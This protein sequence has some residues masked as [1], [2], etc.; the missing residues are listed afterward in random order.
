MSA[1]G[2]GLTC[3]FGYTELHAV[4]A[5]LHLAVCAR[6]FSVAFRAPWHLCCLVVGGTAFNVVFRALLS[7]VCSSTKIS[8]AVH[9]LFVSSPFSPIFLSHTMWAGNALIACA[10]AVHILLRSSEAVGSAAK[11]AVLGVVALLN[12]VAVGWWWTHDLTRHT[13]RAVGTTTLI[14]QISSLF[15]AYSATKSRSVACVAVIICPI[16]LMTN[17]ALAYVFPVDL[18][19]KPLDPELDDSQLA[20]HFSVIL[21]SIVFGAANLA[22]PAAI[23]HAASKL[24]P[25]TPSWHCNLRQISP[26]LGLME[27]P[28]F[29]KGSEWLWL[30]VLVVFAA[31]MTPGAF[32]DRSSVST[33]FNSKHMRELLSLDTGQGGIVALLRLLFPCAGL[34]GCAVLWR[35][36]A[37]GTTQARKRQLSSMGPGEEGPGAQ[38]LQ[39]GQQETTDQELSDVR[40]VQVPHKKQRSK[41]YGQGCTRTDERAGWT[42]EKKADGSTQRPKSKQVVGQVDAA[43]VA[44]GLMNHSVP[45]WATSHGQV[46][47][48]PSAAP[49]Q[50]TANISQE[51]CGYVRSIVRGLIKWNAL[52]GI[53]KLKDI[54]DKYWKHVPR[55]RA[56]NQWEFLASKKSALDFARECFTPE[57]IDVGKVGDN[58]DEAEFLACLRGPV[59][60]YADDPNCLHAFQSGAWHPPGLSIPTPAGVRCSSG[61]GKRTAEA[62]LNHYCAGSEHPGMHQH[63]LLRIPSSRGSEADDLVTKSAS[64]PFVSSSSLPHF[65]S[66]TTAA[67]QQHQSKL[68]Q[69]YMSEEAVLAQACVSLD[70]TSPGL[71]T[72]SDCS[73]DHWHCPDAK[74]SL[75]P[76]DSDYGCVNQYMCETGM[77]ASSGDYLQQFQQYKSEE[78]VLTQACVSADST[79]P[80]SATSSD[81]PYD[82]C[83]CPDATPKT[84]LSPHHSD[85]ARSSHTSLAHILVDTIVV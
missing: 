37:G 34:S 79:P 22:I 69:Q 60:H 12:T 44:V 66:P 48:V 25:S 65:Y 51:V 9:T 84:S 33:A 6:F 30:S 68:Y 32:H 13:V 72:S 56:C 26:V 43:Q 47:Q 14:L 78:A 8:A 36:M 62:I 39:S 31:V 21:R 58:I 76:H 80:G 27:R 23:S 70:S 59:L 40:T 38:K 77:A 11:L 83:Y 10:V 16:A 64:M 71:S 49:I 7:G 53:A 81:S 63:M 61:A 82:H 67:H 20:P 28:T 18:E 3:R 74:T 54:P 2:A 1:D 45:H 17:K 29:G 41:V 19:N 50:R 52:R 75:L 35:L 42:D 46:Q 73:Y 24:Y 55:A 15:F 4:V 57:H 5:L 85:Y